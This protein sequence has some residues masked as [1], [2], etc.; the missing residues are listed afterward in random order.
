MDDGDA[1]VLPKK[2]HFKVSV[3]DK[4]QKHEKMRET[5]LGAWAGPHI[6]SYSSRAQCALCP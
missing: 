2:L 4:R 5:W 6:P 1:S 3:S